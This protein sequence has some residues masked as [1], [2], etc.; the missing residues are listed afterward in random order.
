MKKYIDCDGV[1]LDTETGLFDAYYE[2]KKLNPE[3]RKRTYLEQLD[4]QYWIRQA[5]VIEDAIAILREYDPSGA[6]I[7][8]MVHSM[9]E[10]IAKIEYFREQKVRNNI[11]IVPDTVTKSSVVSAA[12]NILIDDSIRNLD[13]WQ[14]NGGLP[15]YFG[16]KE[17]EHTTIDTLDDVLNPIKFE[18]TLQRI[19]FH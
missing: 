11:I 12:G 10:A 17:S 6:D 18:Q 3:L 1:I 5:K 4:W 7:L 15:I 9:Q 16:P 8:T 2:Q 19:R 13:D 14:I